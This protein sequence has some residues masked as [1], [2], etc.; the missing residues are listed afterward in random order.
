MNARGS[1]ARHGQGLIGHRESMKVELVLQGDAHCCFWPT[2]PVSTG[3]RAPEPQLGVSV[4]SLLCP[5]R[6]AICREGG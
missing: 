3:P 5:P 6:C 4:P 1:V 2:A